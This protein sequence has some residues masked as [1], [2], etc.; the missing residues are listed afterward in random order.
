MDRRGLEDWCVGSKVAQIIAH[1]FIGF[2]TEGR[3]E[4]KKLVDTNKWIGTS[5]NSAS[6]SSSDCY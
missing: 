3:E 4:L 1:E 5:G 6:S 2:D